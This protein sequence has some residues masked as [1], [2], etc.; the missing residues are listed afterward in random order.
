MKP[1]SL[2]REDFVPMPFGGPEKFPRLW[3]DGL[4]DVDIPE[5]GEIRFRFSRISK[6]EKEDRSG[7]TTSVE[8][9]L[10]K[11]TD[12]CD[13]KGKD[14]EYNEDRGEEMESEDEGENEEMDAEEALDSIM[15]D[16]DEE[17]MM[18]ESEDDNPEKY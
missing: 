5:E 7:E 15:E 4:T 18:D 16:L 10:K 14:A 3:L 2:K 6:I 12:I 9:V 8:L 13:C 1:V 17:D 11:I